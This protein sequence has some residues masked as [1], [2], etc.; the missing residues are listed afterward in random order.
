MNPATLRPAGL[1]IGA[2][3]YRFAAR[4]PSRTCPAAE[5][6]KRAPH[7]RTHSITSVPASNRSSECAPRSTS[8]RREPE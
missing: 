3:G 2:G 1:G 8:I 4:G 7:R 6:E 5:R